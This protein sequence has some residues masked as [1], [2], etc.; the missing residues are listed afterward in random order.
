MKHR[1]TVPDALEA[2]IDAATEAATES[3]TYPEAPTVG[4]HALVEL[5]APPEEPEDG[6]EEDVDD[7][8]EAGSSEVLPSYVIPETASWKSRHLG[9][10][11]LAI[12]TV[13][14]FMAVI[15]AAV[16]YW[17]MRT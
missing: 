3:E 12:S 8:V 4:R 7:L 14:A 9:R 17:Q 11:L 13:A 6:P 16:H 10:T 15:P 1:A 5:P 2:E